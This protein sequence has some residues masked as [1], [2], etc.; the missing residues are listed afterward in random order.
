MTTR[1]Y[2]LN[3]GVH[4]IPKK[5]EDP[6]LDEFT[7]KYNL[8]ALINGYEAEARKILEAAGYPSTLNEL[9]SMQRENLPDQI[10]DI[11]DM[12]AWFQNVRMW[13]KDN[14]AEWAAYH[15]A[16][17][18]NAAVR[19]QM[20]PIEPIVDKGMNY[21]Y[22]QSKKA[23]KKRTVKDF[24]PEQREKRNKD[25]KS[26]FKNWKKTAH[27]FDIKYAR[28]YNLSPSAIRKIRES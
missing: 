7:P 10:R 6:E 3:E 28:K 16:F 21:S 25:I 17:A 1:K 5:N 23:K 12:F 24:T 4:F 20:R 2:K 26:A 13:I 22:V 19:A 18:I 15:M 8:D 27:S 9:K 14:L 11:R